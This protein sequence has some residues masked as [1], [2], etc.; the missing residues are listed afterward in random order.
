MKCHEEPHEATRRK[1]YDQNRNAAETRILI[2]TQQKK[3]SLKNE[4]QQNILKVQRRQ[5]N[6]GKEDVP[7]ARYIKMTQHKRTK[8]QENRTRNIILNGIP[9]KESSSY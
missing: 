6:H 9:H 4:K 3:P 8:L 1:S 7:Q 2:V 5:I